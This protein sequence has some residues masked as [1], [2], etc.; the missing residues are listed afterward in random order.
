MIKVMLIMWLC[1]GNSPIRGLKSIWKSICLSCIKFNQSYYRKVFRL[2]TR[3]QPT[4][5]IVR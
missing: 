4:N 1:V 2:P 5:L 3:I